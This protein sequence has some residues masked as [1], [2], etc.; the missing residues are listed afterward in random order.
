MRLIS[1][2]DVCRVEII[3]VDNEGQRGSSE[4][5]A[6]VVHPSNMEVGGT[7]CVAGSLNHFTWGG[8]FYQFSSNA[9]C[10]QDYL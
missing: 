5:V 3:N 10:V 1:L 7:W 2:C 9:V 6:D 8:D 4:N